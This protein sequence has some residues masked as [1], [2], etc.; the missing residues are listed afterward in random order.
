[1]G[2]NYF[3]IKK[4]LIPRFF[5]HR[6]QRWICGY[7]LLCA[8]AATPAEQEP[9]YNGRPLS[10]WIGD[11]RLSAVTSGHAPYDEAIRAM[12]TN[13]IPTLLQWISYEPSAWQQWTQTGKAVP[14]WQPNYNLNPEERAERAQYAFF[15]LGAVGR[16]AIPELTRLARTSPDPKRAER[17]AWSLAL[18]GPESIPSL[19]SLA[20]NG[21]P[22]ARYAG[23]FGLERFSRQP[24]GLQTLPVLMSCLADTNTQVAGSAQLSLLNMGP[25]IAVPAL[26]NVLHSSSTQTRQLALGCLGLFEEENRTN[27]PP[28]MVPALRAAMHDPDSEVRSIAT[29]ILGRM[30]N[31]EAPSANQH[32]QPTPR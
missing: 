29:N 21:P 27:L 32:L 25:S 6:L 26:S 23:A 24:E 22:W 12:G 11:M 7:F 13:A 9:S 8:L 17:C 15:S 20:T 5:S 14:S 1:M 31:S 4:P 2:V 19:I 10:Q 18:I 16:P 30:G 28:T 3:T